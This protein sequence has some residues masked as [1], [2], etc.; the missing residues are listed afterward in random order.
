M[1]DWRKM[2]PQRQHS[3]RR[4]AGGQTASGHYPDSV[5]SAHSL[6]ENQILPADWQPP[7]LGPEPGLAAVA[8]LPLPAAAVLQSAGVPL[9]RGV[10]GDQTI[11]RP[12]RGGKV[13]GGPLRRPRRW[14]EVRQAK[15]DG[16][17]ST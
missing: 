2:A 16:G 6:A 9:Q 17:L 7:E 14:P 8:V 3:D 5:G 1:A 15:Q 11:D 10:Q 4:T 13:D 12:P